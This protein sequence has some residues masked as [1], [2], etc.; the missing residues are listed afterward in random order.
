MLGV[1]IAAG[2]LYPFFRRGPEP[3][4]R[5]GGHEPELGLGRHEFF[6]LAQAAPLKTR[7]FG[8]KSRRAVKES[9]SR[10]RRP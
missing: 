3:N 6:A 7:R 8:A 10:R 5:R 1:P 4:D 9:V 2:A